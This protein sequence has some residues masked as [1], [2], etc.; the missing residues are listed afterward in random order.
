MKIR[1]IFERT[2]ETIESRRMT[3]GF[4]FQC[5]FANYDKSGVTSLA[6]FA[7]LTLPSK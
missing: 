4:L 6:S 3:P 1:V 2:S 5:C 7:F